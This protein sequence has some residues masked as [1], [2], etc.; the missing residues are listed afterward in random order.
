M[1]A[2]RCYG[3]LCGLAGGCLLLS[4]VNLQQRSHNAG[5]FIVIPEKSEAWDP[6]DLAHRYTVSFFSYKYNDA[7]RFITTNNGRQNKDLAYFNIAASDNETN[8]TI[9]AGL[10]VSYI[11]AQG[12]PF[13]AGYGRAQCFA[14]LSAHLKVA[15]GTALYTAD[16][17]DYYF[18]FFGE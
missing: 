5:E 4:R 1:P 6:A 16:I 7:P 15:S 11:E 8:A 14:D 2:A 18:K 12:V 17:V 10:L 13:H 9:C 3:G